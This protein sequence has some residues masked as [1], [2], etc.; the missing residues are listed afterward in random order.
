[1]IVDGGREMLERNLSR[2][3]M[4]YW[5]EIRLDVIHACIPLALTRMENIKSL[6]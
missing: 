5:S 2:Q 1:M 6:V 3:L 4:N